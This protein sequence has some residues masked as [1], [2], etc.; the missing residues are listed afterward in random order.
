V[1]EADDEADRIDLSGGQLLRFCWLD[2]NE[3]CRPNRASILPG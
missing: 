1:H 3:M 2:S